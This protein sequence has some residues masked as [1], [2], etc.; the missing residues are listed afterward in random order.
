MLMEGV[1]IGDLLLVFQNSLRNIA[2]IINCLFFILSGV[3]L[4]SI[5]G[6]NTRN[7]TLNAS[8]FE[9]IETLNIGFREI[10]ELFLPRNLYTWE[11]FLPYQVFAQVIEIHQFFQ[12]LLELFKLFIH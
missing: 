9:A 11:I 3:K 8:E 12:S 5:G 10:L 4:D 1:K 7:S 2:L 6:R